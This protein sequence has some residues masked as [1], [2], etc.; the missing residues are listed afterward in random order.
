MT[1]FY[2]SAHALIRRRDLFL[3]TRRSQTN[4]YWPLKWDLPGG[5]VEPGESLE[6]ALHREVWEETHLKVQI[7]RVVHAYTHLTALP[8]RQTFQILYVCTYRSGSV[9]LDPRE[10][11]DYQWLSAEQMSS[12]DAVPL[13]VDYL[14]GDSML[15]TGL[16]RR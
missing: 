16:A 12:L 15:R 11:D 8:D 3:V 2:G 9:K 14:A 6:S 7:E 10:H 5:N 1:D 13:I 4:D